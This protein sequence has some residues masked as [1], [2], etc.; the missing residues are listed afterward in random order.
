[1]FKNYQQQQQQQQTEFFTIYLASFEAF[2]LF[3]SLTYGANFGR[4]RLDCITN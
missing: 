4:S 2:L 3:L 1:M